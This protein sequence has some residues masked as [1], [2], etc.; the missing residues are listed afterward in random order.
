[1]RIMTLSL[2]LLA[3]AG[4]QTSSL[5][6]PDGTAIVEHLVALNAE[7]Q[8]MAEAFN[9]VND[10][11]TGNPVQQAAVRAKIAESRANSQAIAGSG[12]RVLEALMTV[13]YAQL[14]AE[15]QATLPSAFGSLG[16]RGGR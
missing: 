4:C 3:L 15:L 14:Y 16:F 7:N 11:A 12:I 8:A 2:V 6:K 5:S 1:M 9:A 13:D 10:V